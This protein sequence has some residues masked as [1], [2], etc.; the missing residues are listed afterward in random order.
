MTTQGW[1][2][3]FSEVGEATPNAPEVPAAH[4]AVKSKNFVVQRVG[5]IVH[6]KEIEAFHFLMAGD[7]GAIVDEWAC[8]HDGEGLRFTNA[9]ATL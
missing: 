1:C 2:Y 8:Y 5:D 4:G 7:E 9:K 3:N 6:L